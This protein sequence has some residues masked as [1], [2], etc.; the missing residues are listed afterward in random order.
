M[1]MKYVAKYGNQV[2][3]FHPI[4]VN[5]DNATLNCLLFSNRA[6]K[7]SSISTEWDLETGR[8]TRT[9]ILKSPLNA[10]GSTVLLTWYGAVVAETERTCRSLGRIMASGPGHGPKLVVVPRLEDGLLVPLMPRLE[11]GLGLAPVPWER[12]G[13]FQ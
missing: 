4:T 9:G 5:K 2:T 8:W 7:Y 11:E 12:G 3:K 6:T 13:Q 1:S 10:I